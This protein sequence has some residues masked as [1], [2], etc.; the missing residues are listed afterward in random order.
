MGFSFNS[1][2]AVRHVEHS[3]KRS[4][5]MLLLETL[6]WGNKTFSLLNGMNER[7]QGM[8]EWNP[9]AMSGILTLLVV[10]PSINIFEAHLRMSSFSLSAKSILNFVQD[11][12]TVWKYSQTHLESYNPRP[13]NGA[14]YFIKLL[15]P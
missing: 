11:E 1:D 12:R 3:V 15:F 9:V 5:K 13:Y 2:N 6:T 10:I 4:H 7:C 14:A 8:F